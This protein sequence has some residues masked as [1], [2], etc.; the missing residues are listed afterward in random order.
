M[1]TAAQ[2]KRQRE[3]ARRELASDYK[4]LRVRV[5]HAKRERVRR[6]KRA[7][8]VCRSARA[9]VRPKSRE[10]RARHTAAAQAEIEALRVSA[11]TTCTITRSA[12]ER[13]AARSVA[14]A[15]AALDAERIYQATI[16]RAARKPRLTKD[17]VRRAA[18]ER[19][20]ES[21]D[22]V[23]ANLP[24]ELQ[25][26]WRARAAKTKPTDRATRTEV[27]LDWAHNHTS[28]VAR[29][30]MADIDRQIAELVQEE[31][32]MRGQAASGRP[33][34]MRRSSVVAD[35]VVPF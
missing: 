8:I 5:K 26:V 2:V 20:H 12:A 32:A 17:D 14:R 13:K 18:R 23:A 27:F 3:R 1:L 25:A 4:K 15:G 22:E 16:D 21:D 19:S 34:R 11:R 9:S 28:D 29:L 24:E 6:G 33:P 10:I 30:A 31:S 35:E 7:R